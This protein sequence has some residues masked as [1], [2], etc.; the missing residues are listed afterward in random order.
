MAEIINIEYNQPKQLGFIIDGNLI[1]EPSRWP[2]KTVTYRVSVTKEDSREDISK[3]LHLEASYLPYL[4]KLD[5]I[6][7]H[8]YNAPMYFE[9]TYSLTGIE[10][11]KENKPHLF[12][13]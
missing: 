4:T 7:L 3:C 9:S 8:D 5:E 1:E 13:M 11:L 12:V 6:F 2:E 10:Q